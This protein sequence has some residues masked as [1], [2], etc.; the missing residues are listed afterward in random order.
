M[1]RLIAFPKEVILDIGHHLD[2]KDLRNLALT[3]KELYNL[4]NHSGFVY[5]EEAAEEREFDNARI[6]L[7]ENDTSVIDFSHYQIVNWPESRAALFSNDPDHNKEYFDFLDRCVRRWGAGILYYAI[8]TVDAT[9]DRNLVAQLPAIHRRGSLIHR[10]IASCFD[11]DIIDL[12]I[13][14]YT[15]HYPEG[16]L[17]FKDTSVRRGFSGYSFTND[18]VP[19]FRACSEGRA[20]IVGLI[21]NHCGEKPFNL[22]TDRTN[23][24]T[25]H[26]SLTNI[27]GWMLSEEPDFMDPWECGFHARDHRNRPI[28]HEDVCIW[29]LR[30]DLGFA[31]RPGG[32]PTSHLAE[33]A[34]KKKARLVREMSAYF[35]ARLTQG[36][37]EPAL[38]LAFHAASRGWTTDEPES[39]WRTGG[40]GGITW[41]ATPDGHGE[42]VNAL[43]EATSSSPEYLVQQ[44]L[45][46]RDDRGHLARAVRCAPSNA[47]K[48]LKMQLSLNLV[49]FRDMRAALIEA[50]HF[51]GN[52]D[53]LRLRF[54]KYIIPDRL[55][56]ACDP[57]ELRASPGRYQQEVHGLKKRLRRELRHCFNTQCFNTGLYLVQCLGR[58]AVGKR[59]VE[60]LEWAQREQLDAASPAFAHILRLAM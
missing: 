56:L 51:G 47:L 40:W 23:Q 14:G 19:L 43:F 6:R 1:C 20:D 34:V 59:F 58:E 48:L 45:R 44:D 52:G 46:R 9:W 30:N 33:A 37:F 10:A 3:S 29:L 49:D 38:T 50:I 24:M 15:G 60:D 4:I 27:L 13:R 5:E 53:T 18:P 22:V 25:H 31:S 35:A 41:P 28:I 17:G 42:V 32:I 2:I 16:I 21:Y 57:E 26:A 12:V 11:I 8:S 54:F 36:E 55:E 7:R 39:P